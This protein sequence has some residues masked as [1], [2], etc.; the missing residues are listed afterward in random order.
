LSVAP[1]ERLEEP[2]DEIVLNVEMTSSCDASLD[3]SARGGL[4]HEQMQRPS[5]N[6]SSTAHTTVRWS[7]PPGPF[8]TVA[9]APSC[10]S[11]A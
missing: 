11:R 9:D 3:R 10:S 6:T 1:G 7:F 8:A 4:D 5:S 2:E